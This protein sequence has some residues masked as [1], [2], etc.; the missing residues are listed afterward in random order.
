MQ[1]EKQVCGVLVIETC[2]KHAQKRHLHLQMEGKIMGEKW[3][4]SLS[5][6]L[7]FWTSAR[8]SEVLLKTRRGYQRQNHLI[9]VLCWLS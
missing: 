5:A 8:L 7:T 2:S 6:L 1:Q 9:S 4:T 3:L